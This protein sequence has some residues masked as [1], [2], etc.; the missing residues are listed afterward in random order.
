MDKRIK[1]T[2]GDL[3][4]TRQKTNIEQRFSLFV[5]FFTYQVLN[6]S[7]NGKQLAKNSID[8]NMCPFTW[9][10]EIF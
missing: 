9:A 4:N 6:L 10:N 8:K 3:Q 2:N 5:L 7:D 1:G